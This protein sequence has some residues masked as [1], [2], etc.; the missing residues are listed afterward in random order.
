MNTPLPATSRPHPASLERAKSR[1]MP[2]VVPYLFLMPFLVLF[3]VF[4]FYPLVQSVMLAFKQTSGPRAAEFVGLNNFKWMLT[5]PDFWTAVK[6]T[7]VFASASLLIQLP[8]ALG[9]AMLL[10]RKD[11]KG[12][13]FWRMIFFAPS[14][15]G[16]AFMAVLSMLLF[17]SGN[18]LVNIW[19]NDITM[20]VH[21]TVPFLFPRHWVWD[22]EFAWLQEY[23]M[24]ALIITAFWMYVGFNMVY[25]LAALQNVNPNLLEAAS[26]DGATAWHRFIHV[27]IPAIRP[28]GS[29]VVLLS[30]IGSFQLFELPYLLFSGTAGPNNQGL[31]VVMYLYDKGFNAGDLGY[32]SA[33]GWVLALLLSAL[34]IVQRVVVREDER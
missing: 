1:L 15:V 3:V 5:D 7:T 11:V 33:V 19:L 10:N 23:V 28:V 21:Q 27:T 25:F 2:V 9:L 20:T 4:L 24:P 16:L 34:A 17:A 14:L 30:M 26:V 32:A 13:A 6:N 18:G 29:F 12:S 22:P 31:T 8:C